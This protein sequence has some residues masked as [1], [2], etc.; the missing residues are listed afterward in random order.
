MIVIFSHN[1]EENVDLGDLDNHIKMTPV[2]KCQDGYEFPVYGL[3]YKGR[4]FKYV[5]RYAEDPLKTLKE[6]SGPIPKDEFKERVK[7]LCRA[8]GNII[9]NNYEIKQSCCI[10][11]LMTKTEN[12]D[13]GGLVKRIMNCVHGQSQEMSEVFDANQRGS[14]GRSHKLNMADT[15]VYNGRFNCGFASAVEGPDSAPTKDIKNRRANKSKPREQESHAHKQS[16]GTTRTPYYPD[17]RVRGINHGIYSNNEAQNENTAQLQRSDGESSSSLPEHNKILPPDNENAPLLAHEPES[18]SSRNDEVGTGQ[19]K[20]SRTRNKTVQVIA[21]NVQKAR[22]N[23][24]DETCL[25]LAGKRK[26]LQLPFGDM[27]SSTPNFSFTDKT[28]DGTSNEENSEEV[29]STSSNQSHDL[30]GV[31]QEQRQESQC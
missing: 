9:N 8:V 12:L 11:M 28:D 24:E 20:I 19:R 10:L 26:T 3:W 17:E 18:N 16:G 21:H 6:M 1:Y 25:P 15:W 29:L 5:I 4:E 13:N 22:G 23:D 14:T 7:L 27:N 2:K 31:E 30:D